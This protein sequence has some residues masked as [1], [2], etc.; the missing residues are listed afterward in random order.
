MPSAGKNG[1][2]GMKAPDIYR[3]HDYREFLKA[4]LA[5]M[6]GKATGFS[7]R[8]LAIESKMAPGYISMVLSGTRGL[9]S[10]GLSKMTGPLDL[11]ASEGKYLELLRIVAES[12][13][14]E[15]RLKALD[16]IHRYR[17]YRKLNPN[18]IEVYRYLTH[19]YNVAIRELAALPDFKADPA[20]IQ[21][22]LRYKVSLK[23]IEQ[24]LAFLKES[25]YL[26]ILPDGKARLPEKDVKCLGGV[27]RIAI[28]QFH[29]EMLSLAI[30]SLE[31]VPPAERNI[32]GHT[33]A[34]AAEDFGEVKRILDDAL[35]RV[36]EIGRRKKPMGQVIQVSLAAFPLTDESRSK[37]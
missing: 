24:S 22:R 23:E 9:T 4:R 27:F 16:G 28:Q 15:V 19:W 21:Q 1:G 17:S 11:T 2:P 12:D 7:L 35:E 13:S 32:V 29:G 34:I 5:Y 36:A 37:K 25:G 31:S 20:W 14:Q 26:E 18:E 33:T 6:K 8:S 10:E 30:E 3:Y